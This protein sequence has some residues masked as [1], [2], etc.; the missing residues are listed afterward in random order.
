[1]GD[2]HWC[3]LEDWWIFRNI[4]PNLRK[5]HGFWSL[6]SDWISALCLLGENRFVSPLS[7]DLV[8]RNLFAMAVEGVVFFL[9]TVL[10]QYRF[11]IRPRWALWLRVTGEAHRETLTNGSW[12]EPNSKYV[13]KLIF[14]VR[15]SRS[16]LPAYPGNCGEWVLWYSV[17]DWIFVLKNSLKGSFVLFFPP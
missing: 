3:L 6:H 11:F 12:I 13:I 5:G 16:P 7:W 14:L 10:I 2:S 17:R 9:I 8:G 15:T 4:D 1:M